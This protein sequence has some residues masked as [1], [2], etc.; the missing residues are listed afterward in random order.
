MSAAPAP[1]LEELVR[2]AGEGWLLDG[3]S[4]REGAVARLRAVL[5]DA[6]AHLR[7]TAGAGGPGID[8]ESLRAEFERSP[9]KA[10][11]FL[12]AVGETESPGM[13][14]MVWRL[15]QGME[16][17]EVEMKYTLQKQFMLRVKL[18]SP[19]DG[20]VESYASDDI[21]DATVFRHLG[22]MK[23]DGRPVFDGFYPV[24]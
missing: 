4:P 12:Q 22:I 24:G 7:A 3:Q 15:L 2:Q 13:L 10:R 14:A 6:D 5:A 1:G 20:R 9:H 16:V 11:A 23:M 18:L 21:D 17:G 8:E 19:D